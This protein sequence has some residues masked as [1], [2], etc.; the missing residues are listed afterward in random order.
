MG[1]GDPSDAWW[2]VFWVFL[3]G[4]LVGLGYPYCMVLGILGILGILESWESWYSWYSCL[5]WG[6]VDKADRPAGQYSH[7][8]H[9]GRRKWCRWRYIAKSIRT[10]LS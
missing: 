5:L 10:K 1:L 6:R 3:D 2:V 4:D 7:G 8:M 9:T